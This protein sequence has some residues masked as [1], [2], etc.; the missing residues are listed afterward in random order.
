MK[1]SIFLFFAAILCAIGTNA[2]TD[3]YLRGIGTWDAKGQTKMTASGS[4]YSLVVYLAKSTTYEFKIA[5]SGW[6][7]NDTYAANNT[8]ENV[9]LDTEYQTWHDGGKGNMKFTPS[10]DGFYN[11]SLTSGKLTISHYNPIPTAAPAEVVNGTNVMFYIMGYPDNNFNVLRAKSSHNIDSH[12]RGICKGVDGY[13]YV[14]TA[15]TNLSTNTYVSNNPGGWT[16]VENTGIEDAEGG[17]LFKAASTVST[18]EAKKATTTTSIT[19][20]NLNI[21]TTPNSTTGV[22][23]GSLYIQYYLEG[24]FIGVTYNSAVATYESI[25]VENAD[26]KTSTYDISEL[27]YGTYT[28]KTVLTD[29]IVYYIAD[30]DQFTKS[31]NYNLTVT[32][33]KGI[34]IVTGSTDPITL[35]YTYPITAEVMVG[36]QFEKWVASPEENGEF[37][38]ATE[39]NTNVLVKN[40][41]VTVTASATEI[42]SILTTANSYNVGTPDAAAPAISTNQIGVATHATVAAESISGYTLAGWTLTNCERVD[43]GA[44]NATTITVK[45]TGTDAAATVTANYEINKYYVVGSFNGWNPKDVNYEMTYDNGIYSHEFTNLAA[46]TYQFRIT[47]GSWSNTWGWNEVENKDYA[48]LSAGD[49]DNNI[50]L[51]LTAAKTVTVNYNNTTEKVSIEGLTAVTYSDITIKAY[52]ESAAPQ[53]WWWDGGSKCPDAEKTDNPSNPGN[54]YTW[55]TAPTMTAVTGETNWYEYTF[56]DVNDQTGICFKFKN[57]TTAS[58]NFQGIKADACYDVRDIANAKTTE[59][60]V[61][62]SDCLECSGVYLKGEFNTWLPDNEFMKTGDANVVTLSITLEKGNYDFKVHGDEWY[63]NTGDMTRENTNQAWT[64]SKDVDDKANIRVDVSGEYI[65]S[66]KISEKQLTVTYPEFP[67]LSTQPEKLYFRPTTDWKSANAEFAAFFLDGDKGT[68]AKWEDFTDADGDGVY[69][70]DNDKKYLTIIICRMNPEGTDPDNWKNKWNQSAD[71]TIPTTQYLNSWID[72][73][74][75]WDGANGIWTVLVG[76]S[77]NSTTLSAANSQTVNTLVNRQFESGKLYTISL[78][79]ALDA[80]QVETIFGAGTTLYQFAQLAKEGGE[81]VL[82]FSKPSA[83]AAATPYLIQPT[84]NVAAGFTVEDATISTTPNNISFTV[85]ATTVT[86]KPILSATAGEKTNGTT[87]YWL[88]DNTYLYNNANIVLSLRALF[89]IST[90]SGMPPR[91][92]VALGENAETGVDNIITTDAPVKVIEN[93]Q[94]I[95]IRNGEKFNAQGQ[96]L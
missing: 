11:F 58:S 18:V 10:A 27:A 75:K 33:G 74:N 28:L 72:N 86:M 29:G 6:N 64:F 47:D 2:A 45:S 60:G 37:A 9:S 78:P 94:L 12:S 20:D 38:E 41:S 40:G 91:C 32:A 52:T 90:V 92:R 19:G 36:Y 22:L 49:N 61:T 85:D 93:G 73:E 83:I 87:E 15:K 95:I 69:E 55:E 89:N 65:F 76:E 62:P 43:G 8:N 88:A 5:D 54:K 25:K 30:E 82:Y 50:K 53:I 39:A 16:G 59:C 24:D 81:L 31:P 1:K 42:L 57:A 48:E 66:W 68:N 77:D 80:E 34:S 79:F 70:V 63:G 23:N 3:L 35:N 51:T 46:G 7:Y 26:A 14:N 4:T 56:K 96:K 13:S 21:S 44:E 17:E 67:S 71:L 84:Q